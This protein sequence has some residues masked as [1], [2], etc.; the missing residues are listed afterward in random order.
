MG[1]KSKAGVTPK[2]PKSKT[3]KL[4]SSTPQKSP[5]KK[6]EPVEPAVKEFGYVSKKQV[7][8]AIEELKKFHE[9]TA[10]KKSTGKSDLFADADE[11]D[12]EMGVPVHVEV[13]AKKFFTDK[14]NIKPKLIP[15]PKSLQKENPKLTVCLLVRDGLITSEEQLRSI[16]EAKVPFLLKIVPLADLKT[17]YQPYDKREELLAEYDCFV[18][19]DAILSSMPSVLG[20]IFYSSAKFPRPVKPVTSGKK[21]HPFTLANQINKVLLSAAYLCPVGPKVTI[22]VGTLGPY[23]TQD[24]LIANIEP[25]LQHFSPEKLVSVSLSIPGSPSLPLF[26]ADKIYDDADV[27]ENAPEKTD[28]N[29]EDVYTQAMLELA[30]EETVAKL[31]G[32]KGRK[33]KKTKDTGRV[34][35]P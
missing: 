33:A 24:E 8:R 22:N 23:F 27:L 32:K 16:E 9:R 1:K 26:Y 30:D 2:T 29:D 25:V 5:A 6:T 10:E 15:V 11:Q 31:L 21:F 19:D 14:G 3:A 17:M 35:K 4:A 12:V 28:E 20:K 18:V 7:T 34:E 13:E